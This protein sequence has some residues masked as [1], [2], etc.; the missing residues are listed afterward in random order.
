MQSRVL[1]G[2]KLLSGMFLSAFRAFLK[3][4]AVGLFALG[5][6]YELH[7]AGGAEYRFKT[8]HFQLVFT[9]ATSA[10]LRFIFFHLRLLAC[11]GYLPCF[12][13]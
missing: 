11:Y 12:L 5:A 13:E 2:F 4:R 9:K 3:L 7:L 8:G 10:F 6:L 1:A